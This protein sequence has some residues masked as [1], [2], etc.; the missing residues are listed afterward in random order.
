MSLRR[1][2]NR[3]ITSRVVVTLP[4]LCAMM[5]PGVDGYSQTNK[6]ETGTLG[7]RLLDSRTGEPLIGATVMIEGTQLGSQS[8]LDGSYRIRL[9]PTGIVTLL[10]RAIG[11]APFRRH[12]HRTSQAISPAARWI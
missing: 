7:G 1:T 8:D 3:V 2:V 12:S 10:V 6:V 5:A 4:V 11:Y 9:V